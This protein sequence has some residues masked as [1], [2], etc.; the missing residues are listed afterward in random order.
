MLPENIKWD[1]FE[2]LASGKSDYCCKIISKH[3]L[4]K[5]LNTS[6]LLMSQ[7]VWKSDALF[8]PF[9][10]I[11]KVYIRC[12]LTTRNVYKKSLY[13]NAKVNNF[14]HHCFCFIFTIKLYMEQEQKSFR[15]LCLL[16]PLL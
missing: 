7:T 12:M 11:H 5:I 1:H 13:K 10:A 16:V 9:F 2:I 3:F 14:Y 6:Q 15:N 8:V 4:Y